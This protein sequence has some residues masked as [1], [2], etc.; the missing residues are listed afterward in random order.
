MA[1]ETTRVAPGLFINRWIGE[2]TLADVV[3]SETAGQAMLQPDETRVVLVNDLSAAT[4][5]PLDI[6]ALQRIAET[7]PQV[8]ALLVVDAPS[9]I[10]MVGEA[11]A[12][13]GNWLVEFYD[14]LDAAL[15][16][17]RGLLE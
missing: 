4:R 8:I 12:K 1:I 10:R 3:E 16:R 14:T 7:N 11:Q 17:G 13:R 2:V 9:M 6:K 5:F 15:E